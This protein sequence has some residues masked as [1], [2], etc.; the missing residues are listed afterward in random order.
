MPPLRNITPPKR[1]GRPTKLPRVRPNSGRK[2]IA[3]VGGAS[4]STIRNRALEI[5]V[6]EE[7]TIEVIALALNIKKRRE[8]HLLCGN[9]NS[10]TE[11]D[12]QDIEPKFT[13]HTKESGLALFLEGNYTTENYI[14]LYKDSRERGCPIYVS[15]D[16]IKLAK[17]EC[18]VDV[19]YSETEV[20][21]SM[22]QMLNKTAERLYK[23]VASNWTGP[24]LHDLG[25]NFLGSIKFCF[26]IN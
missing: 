10:N 5:L 13:K 23:A 6:N 15:Y 1:S 24:T 21:V 14:A 12:S 7:N 19:T 8:S 26:F 20:K 17:E 22:Q 4:R 3:V 9:E 25:I 2:R 16:D 18:K 11:N